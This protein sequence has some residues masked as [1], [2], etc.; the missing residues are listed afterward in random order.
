MS[1]WHYLS[2]TSDGVTTETTIRK[3]GKMKPLFLSKT[4]WATVLAWLL[5]TITTFLGGEAVL[6]WLAAHPGVAILVATVVAGINIALRWITSDEIDGI[7]PGPK[8]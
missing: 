8:E 4:F 1:D 3:V 2:V 6:T 7:L 5:S